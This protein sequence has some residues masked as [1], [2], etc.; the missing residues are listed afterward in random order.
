VYVLML[1]WMNDVVRTSGDEIVEAHHLVTV[2]EK[3]IGE[4]RAQESGGA[5]DEHPHAIRPTEL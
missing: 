1:C 2:G 3:A 4:V 5:G